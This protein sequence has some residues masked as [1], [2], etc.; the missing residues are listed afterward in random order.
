MGRKLWSLVFPL[1]AGHL[2]KMFSRG[3]GILTDQSSKVQMPGGNYPGGMLKLR[4]NGLITLFAEMTYQGLQ[5][6]N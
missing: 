2:N 4:M 5:F 6:M 1:A 3:A